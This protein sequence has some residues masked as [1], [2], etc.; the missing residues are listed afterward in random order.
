MRKGS[1]PAERTNQMSL[2]PIREV[3]RKSVRQRERQSDSEVG[4][5]LVRLEQKQEPGSVRDR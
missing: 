3:K 1:H 5:C 2:K 4:M